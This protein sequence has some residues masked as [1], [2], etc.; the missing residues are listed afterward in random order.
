MAT[1]GYFGWDK[2]AGGVTL[3]THLRLGLGMGAVTTLL[4]LYVPSRYVQGQTGLHFTWILNKSNQWQSASKRRTSANQTTV[5]Y[6]ILL[7]GL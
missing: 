3:M 6:N 5:I 4:Y 7:T 1:V 2:A